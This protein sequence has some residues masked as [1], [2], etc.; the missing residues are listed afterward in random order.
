LDCAGEGEVAQ[1]FRWDAS[2]GEATGM[3]IL[4]SVQVA[5]GKADSV[6]G[7]PALMPKTFGLGIRR[8]LFGDGAGEWCLFGAGVEGGGF[9]EGDL[10][11]CL[12]FFFGGGVVTGAAGDNE[13]LAGEYGHEAAFGIDATDAEGT[14]E[15]EKHLVSVVMG[16]K[17]P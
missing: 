10:D 5:V 12:G 1:E 8:E 17:P 13:E 2:I 6:L 7:H 14:T 3:R 15:D 9:D 16:G 4:Y 11:S